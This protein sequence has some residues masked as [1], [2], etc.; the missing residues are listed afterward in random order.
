MMPLNKMHLA[1]VC[2]REPE[3]AEPILRT[4]IFKRKIGEREQWA[5]RTATRKIARFNGQ[6]SELA[7]Y[8]LKKPRNIACAENDGK[9]FIQQS[10]SGTPRVPPTGIRNQQ[11][12]T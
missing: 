11:P 12:V 7:P 9:V 8:R 10:F 1:L 2:E 4:C 3:T 6:A 5:I